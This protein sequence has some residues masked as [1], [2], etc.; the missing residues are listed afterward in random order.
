MATELEVAGPFKIN[1]QKGGSGNTKRIDKQ[2]IK[3]F[4]K[5]IPSQYALKCGC[6]VFAIQASQ[7]FK[8]WYVGKASKGFK[9]E[10]FTT[11][12]LNLYNGVL[13]DGVHGTPVLFFIA[14][15]GSKKKV[16]GKE[17]GHMEKELIQ[18]ALV[19]NNDLANTSNTGNLPRWS[20]K[21][22]VRAGK[23]NPTSAAKAFKKMMGM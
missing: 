23:G 9:Q 10:V 14:P 16:P 22:V 11:H 21:G 13:F 18:D 15:C 7:G 3:N 17:L 2:H 19:K 5:S 8:P 1:Y 6:Y 4:W 12:K 20:I